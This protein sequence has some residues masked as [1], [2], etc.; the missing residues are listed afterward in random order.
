[1]KPKQKPQANQATYKESPLQLT[2]FSDLEDEL[3]G[4]PGTPERAEYEARIASEML[5]QTASGES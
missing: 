2:A 3:F 5:P 4:K 1:M